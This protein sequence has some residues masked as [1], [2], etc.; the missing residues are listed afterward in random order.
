ME[1]EKATFG[2]LL[3]VA[4]YAK[5]LFV[6]H[7]KT[8]V[9]DAF[10][11]FNTDAIMEKDPVYEALSGMMGK[12][13]MDDDSCYEFAV[14]AISHV[15]DGAVENA[16]DC[17][18]SEW[19]DQDTDVYTSGLTG[20]LNRSDHNVYYLTEALEE[21]GEKDGFKALQIAQMKARE[22]VYAETISALSGLAGEDQPGEE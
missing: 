8:D 17:D 11:S 10:Y 2:N 1:C 7:T 9:R 22:E 6:Y 16:D 20:W 4:E 3:Q 15:I 19:A 5:K 12:S 13:D 14:E 18:V 21:Y